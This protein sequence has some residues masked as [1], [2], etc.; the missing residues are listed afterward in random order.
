MAQAGGG[1]GGLSCG[2]VLWTRDMSE[3]SLG[4]PPHGPLPGN[5]S[6]GGLHKHELPGAVAKIP[7][8]AMVT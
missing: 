6:L 4:I 3:H 1:G 2:N 5:D 8:R 7:E